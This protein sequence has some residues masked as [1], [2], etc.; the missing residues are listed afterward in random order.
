M[1]F[2]KPCV[3]IVFAGVH[4]HSRETPVAIEPRPMVIAAQPIKT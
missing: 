2:K 1:R 3:L 4:I